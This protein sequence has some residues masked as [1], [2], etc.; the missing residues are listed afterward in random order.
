MTAKESRLG[1][2]HE[3][4]AEH[5][6]KRIE[7]YDASMVLRAEAAS[8]A[9]A[10]AESPSAFDDLPQLD[11]FADLSPALLGVMAKFLKD[12]EIT[13]NADDEASDVNKLKEQLRGRR[14]TGNVEH[15][16]FG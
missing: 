3:K 7:A 2:L 14:T 8:V 16:D 6:I 15:I 5:F 4:L 13:C 10:N 12:N 9:L 11:L 1:A